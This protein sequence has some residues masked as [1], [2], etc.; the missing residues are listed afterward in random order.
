MSDFRIR[1]YHVGQIGTNCYIIFREQLKK[2]IIVDPGDEGAYILEQCRKLSVTPEAIFL[3]HGHF[4]HIMAV[5]EIKQAFPEVIVYAGEEEKMLLADP[6]VNL[7]DN[8]GRLC[9]LAADRYVADGETVEA[10]GIK[11]DV[12]ATP[13][14]TQGCVCYYIKEEDVLISGDTLFLESLG[15]TD[16]PTGDQSAIIRSIK[17]KLFPLPG[18]TMVYPGHGDVTTIGHEKSYNPVAL[19]RG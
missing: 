16:L 3:T 13:G 6:S 10:A 9:S 5:E 8:I 14:H 17:E 4:D 2:A 19:Y 12:I 11:A 7:S 18:D 1:T 15:R